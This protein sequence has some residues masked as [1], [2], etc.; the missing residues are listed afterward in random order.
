MN[1]KSFIEKYYVERRNTQ[2]EKWDNLDAIFTKSD[3]LP[4]WVA[5]MDFKVSDAITKKLEERVAHGVYGYTYVPPSY[6]EVYQKW[7]QDRFQFTVEK[8]WIRFAP[9]V[10]QALFNILHC[11]TQQEDAV[12]ILTP[13]Y[14]PFAD[15]VRHTGRHLVTV[16]LIQQN[17][18]FTIDFQKFEAAVVSSKAKVY[19]HCSPHNPIGRVWTEEEQLKL[20]EICEQHDVLIISD[21]I[22]QDFTF[23]ESR[24]IPSATVAGGRYKHR[25]ITA[26]SASKSFN[27]AGLAHSTIVLEDEGLRAQYDAYA[28]ST[29]ATEFNMIGL[30]ATEA[31]YTGGH[32]WLDMLK[33]VIYANYESA[34]RLFK[35]HLPEVVV[36]PL[37]GTYLLFAD[38]KPILKGHD[39]VDFM[40]NC[41]GIAIDYGEWFGERYQGYIRINLATK[42][43]LIEEAMQRIIREAKALQGEKASPLPNGQ[44]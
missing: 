33:E 15:T 36:T 6:Y 37:E 42:P 35:A 44:L 32:E 28:R 20:F 16:D 21:E 38:L 29:I 11:F 27:I 19:I 9:G 4:L 30:L 18:C 14:Y 7:M 13:V 17:G 22:H 12:V 5:D 2:S 39:I 10:V 25:I 1:Q 40:E 23:G 24:H 43:E 31:A 26:N 34:V 8:E 41:C 3:L